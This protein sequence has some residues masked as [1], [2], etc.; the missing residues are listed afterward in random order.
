VK[1]YTLSGV[2]HSK[3]V[4]PSGY[5]I[6]LDKPHPFVGNIPLPF[7]E[8]SRV[9]LGGQ[10]VVLQII[11]ARAFDIT[12]ELEQDMRF[13]DEVCKFFETLLFPKVTAVLPVESKIK[14]SHILYFSPTGE[15]KTLAQD[16]QTVLK[17]KDIDPNRLVVKYAHFYGFAGRKA[18]VREDD[19]LYFSSN[20]YAHIDLAS[21]LLTWSDIKPNPP[22]PEVGNVLCCSI[23][24][25]F[26]GNSESMDAWF[27]ASPQLQL[28]A[29]LCTG[30]VKMP[31]NDAV[32]QL[33]VP[34][35]VTKMPILHEVQMSRYLY[36]GIWLLMNRKPIPEHYNMPKMRNPV[37]KADDMQ[38]FH[39]WWPREV[40]SRKVTKQTK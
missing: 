11:F 35:N 21:G 5:N 14:V 1:I 37:G 9:D 34:E 20:R 28:L 29:K 17:N 32:E 22:K 33:I 2:I 7:L 10:T 38:P 4:A 26:N 36:A 16:L 15:T 24:G 6:Q 23:S 27:I 13:A 31:I 12:P 40:M 39:I 25:K 3:V 30:Q 18:D 19:S 8:L